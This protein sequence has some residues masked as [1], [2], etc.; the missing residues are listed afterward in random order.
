MLNHAG[1]EGTLPTPTP[2]PQVLSVVL[3]VPWT[4]CAA[5]PELHLCSDLGE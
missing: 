1:R 3:R 4:V 2:T 5:N